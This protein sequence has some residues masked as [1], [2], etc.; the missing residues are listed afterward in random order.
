MDCVKC[1]ELVLKE[2]LNLQQNEILGIVKDIDSKIVDA[3][4]TAAK[5]MN[6]TY[7]I[8]KLDP[9]RANSAPIPEAFEELSQCDAIVAPSLK[10]ISHCSQ[11][12]ELKKMGKRIITLPGIT[13]EI[14]LKIAETDIDAIIKLEEHLH[15]Q[16][17]NG[18]N[19]HITTPN[20][21]DL[22]LVLDPERKWKLSNM[23]LKE[24]KLMNLPTGEI[25]TA[26]IEEKANGT[27]VIDRWQEITPDMKATIEVKDGKIVSWNEAAES[28]IE[29]L[30]EGGE[31]GLIIAE[32]G[33]GTNKS[34]KEPIGNTLHDEKIYGTCHIAF[35]MNASFGGK[36]VAGVHQD[37]ILLEPTITIDGKKINY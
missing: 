16:V 30:R 28:Y 9:E 21:T 34:H 14:F 11:T 10:S 26:P 15:E 3:F 33:I 29:C 31:N 8:I 24:G 37:V 25:F 36:N 27:I 2:Y 4:E 17:R 20:G 18:I 19:A 35:G 23:S 1:A 32:L 13:E 12:T 5:N 6:V 22:K 7:K